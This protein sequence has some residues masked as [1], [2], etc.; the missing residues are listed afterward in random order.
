VRRVCLAVAGALAV[1]Q[2]AAAAAAPALKVERV[3]LLMRHGVRP[4]THEPALAPAIAPDPWPVWDVPDG[5]LT[6]HGAAAITLLGAFD[7]VT[8]ARDGLL[9]AAGCPAAGSVAVYADVDERTVKTGDAFA[10]GLAPGC[11]VAVQHSAAAR[12]KLFSALDD[13][14]PG[15]DAKAAKAAMLAAAGGSAG[16][17][18]TA[19]A[20]L[21]QA[22]QA[23]LDPGGTGF[24][25]LPAK[26]SAKIPGHLPK[27]S[28]PL[29]EGSSGAED[30]LLEYLEG[31]PMAEVGW[32]RV[33]PAEI[34]TL[35]A[36]HPLA[37]TVT[38]RPAYIAARTAGPLAARIAAGLSGPGPA[39][40]VLVGHDTNIAE[41]GGLLD[42]H[43][44]LGGY[45]ADDPPPG[46]GIMF[47]LLRDAAGAHYV[48]AAY[49]V[50]TMAQIRD[51]TPLS[52]NDPPAIEPLPIPG[53]GNSAAVTAC[54]LPDFLKL[55]AA[56]SDSAA[57]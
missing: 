4:P 28:G 43:W 24:L 2:A 13:G 49:Q 11:G 38:A 41:L 16:A 30:F 8:F 31:K 21:F 52:L 56:R 51:L 3:V 1:F 25:D 18:V 42:L 15:F 23:A 45:P 27:L 48:A 53:C 54:P 32:G 19:H 10:A 26:I 14:A 6:A 36:L 55:V 34:A 40:T 57:N 35:L 46:G 44:R 20:A 47:L 9:P 50:Q 29:A 17:V 37:Y 7:R 5:D 39:V 33:S 22:M 12:D